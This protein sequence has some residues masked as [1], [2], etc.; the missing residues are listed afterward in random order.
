MSKLISSYLNYKFRLNFLGLLMTENP[1][2]DNCGGSGVNG[3]GCPQLSFQ[4]L[5]IDWH[6]DQADVEFRG[7]I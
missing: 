4:F 5:V 7:G 3:L 1:S 2:S 6:V